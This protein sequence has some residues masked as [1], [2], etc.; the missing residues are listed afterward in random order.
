MASLKLSLAKAQMRRK[1]RDP[2]PETKG[3][4]A[5]I[6]PAKPPTVKPYARARYAYTGGVFGT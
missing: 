6:K 5:A 1:R 3:K 4:Q 2:R